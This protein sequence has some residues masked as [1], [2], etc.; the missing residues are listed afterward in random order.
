MS[1]E[2]S[3]RG[4]IESEHLKRSILENLESGKWPTDGVKKRK[5]IYAYVQSV[6]SQV[7]FGKR[8][9]RLDLITF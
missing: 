2:F 5:A 6:Q 1:W 4:G 8:E 7:L 9:Q 3:S